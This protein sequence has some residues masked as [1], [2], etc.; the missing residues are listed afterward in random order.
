MVCLFMFVVCWIGKFKNVF[1]VVRQYIEFCGVNIFC[2]ENNGKDE[3]FENLIDEK[4]LI[5]CF[6]C[7]CVK[8]CFIF[9]NCCFDIFFS[10]CI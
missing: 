4:F 8:E 7:L 6:L 10:I 9:G 1:D 5:I 3:M 2:F